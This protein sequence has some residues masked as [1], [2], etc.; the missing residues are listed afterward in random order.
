MAWLEVD[1]KRTLSALPNGSS[2]EDLS[3]AARNGD[4]RAKLSL[5]LMRL[6]GSGLPKDEK[7]G[8]EWLSQAA[9]QGDPAGCYFTGLCHK[10]GL[11]TSAD[12]H[13]AQT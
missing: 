9:R 3:A 7:A 11:G 5:G 12:A 8:F 6:L 2:V 1:A 4:P 13:A 10:L